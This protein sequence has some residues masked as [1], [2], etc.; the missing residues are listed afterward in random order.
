MHK[1]RLDEKGRVT[2]P[3][4]IRDRYS[5]TKGD[6]VRMIDLGNGS[7]EIALLKHSGE[8]LPPI[9]KTKRKVSANEIKKAAARAACTRCKRTSN[10]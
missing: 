5:L 1:V 9:V 10:N 7:V 4:T 6:E 3:K 2:L 8:L